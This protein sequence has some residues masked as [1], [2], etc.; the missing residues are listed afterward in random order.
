M[1]HTQ[2]E[3][4][5]PHQYINDIRKAGGWSIYRNEALLEADRFMK[6]DERA[7][8]KKR[9]YSTLRGRKLRKK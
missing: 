6:S 7:T 9:I 2:Y 8:V 1:K 5:L 4:D 3:P